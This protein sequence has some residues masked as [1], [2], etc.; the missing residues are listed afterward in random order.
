MYHA[1]VML[2]TSKLDIY[3]L[4]YHSL[5]IDKSRVLVFPYEKMYEKVS[6]LCVESDEV[7]VA[8]FSVNRKISETLTC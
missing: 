2:Q 6:R 8:V 4:F 5:G 7:S 3:Q 1:P